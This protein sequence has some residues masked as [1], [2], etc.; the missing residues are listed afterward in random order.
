MRVREFQARAGFLFVDISVLRADRER[1]LLLLGLQDPR[2]ADKD[3]PPSGTGVA[4]EGQVHVTVSDAAP[5]NDE[6]VELTLTDS[7]MDEDDVGHD[8]L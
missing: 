7:E 1:V 3:A 4:D 8:M 6:S 2:G 5:R